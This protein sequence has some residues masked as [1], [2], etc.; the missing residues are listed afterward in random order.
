MSQNMA[1]PPIAYG[2]SNLAGSK[3]RA[4]GL[5]SNT[6]ALECLRED[7]DLMSSLPVSQKFLEFD[8]EALLSGK[9]ADGW[10][11]TN[12]RF[13]DR[14]SFV[15]YRRDP[16]IKCRASVGAVHSGSA[17]RKYIAFIA[18]LG[19]PKPPNHLS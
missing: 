19:V 18:G 12:S 10:N 3:C 13:S 9:L 6:A 14:R 15:S 16:E 7:E 11:F 2:G 5:W 1:V 4:I 8:F 17:L